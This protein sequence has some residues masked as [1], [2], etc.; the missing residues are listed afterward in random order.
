MSPQVVSACPYS[1]P[2]KPSVPGCLPWAAYGFGGAV[3]ASVRFPVDP[4]TVAWRFESAVGSA[5][6]AFMLG[7]PRLEGAGFTVG[8]AAV[9]VV[10]AAAAR[11]AWR[12]TSRMS[13]LALAGT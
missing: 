10:A 12:I 5:R 13:G 11:L 9:A 7:A 4:A 1:L 6:S 8:L 2:T 3:S